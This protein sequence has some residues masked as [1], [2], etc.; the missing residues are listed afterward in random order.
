MQQCNKLDACKQDGQPVLDFLCHLQ[1]IADT[2]G[3][4]SERNVALAFW[5][6]CQPYLQA[7]LTQNRYDV[8]A[9]SVVTLKSECLRYEKAH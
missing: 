9:I 6:C 8:T 5:C 2:I 7:K 1:E 3:D 4:V